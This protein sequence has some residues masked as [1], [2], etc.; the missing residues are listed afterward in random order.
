MWRDAWTFAAAVAITL[1]INHEYRR[2]EE[3]MEKMRDMVQ[4]E[5]ERIKKEIIKEIRDLK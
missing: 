1:L 5:L 3:L 2:R 4:K